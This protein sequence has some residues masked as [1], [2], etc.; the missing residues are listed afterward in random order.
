M[1]E[2]NAINYQDAVRTD[3][4]TDGGKLSFSFI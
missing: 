2:I 1:A 4:G 3:G